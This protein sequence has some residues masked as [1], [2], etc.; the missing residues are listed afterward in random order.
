LAESLGEDRGPVVKGM[1]QE[2]V[3]AYAPLARREWLSWGGELL[4]PELREEV[5]KEEREKEEA[6][7]RE[8]EKE[9]KQAAAKAKAAT[10]EARK[11]ALGEAQRAIMA[12][13]RAKTLSRDELQQRNAEL[14]AEA[15]AIEKE[16]ECEKE[17]D[18]VEEDTVEFGDSSQVVAGKRK[19]DEV[20]ED[21]EG[22][23][24][25]E[26]KRTKDVVNGLLKFAGPVSRIFGLYCR[27]RA[28]C[29]LF[30]AIDALATSRSRRAS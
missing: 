9:S 26:A 5:E 2:V 21:D 29:V 11:A 27:I 30:S 6:R 12:E 8:E 25:I 15:Y 16:E 17:E 20:E 1:M 22:E 13:F 24:E 4:F 14:A 28:K 18:E 7:K 3:G 19:A 10:L 23:D